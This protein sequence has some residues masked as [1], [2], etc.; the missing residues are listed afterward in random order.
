M[1]EKE[2]LSGE[3]EADKFF[4]FLPVFALISWNVTLKMYEKQRRILTTA[5][6]QNQGLLSLIIAIAMVFQSKRKFIIIDWDYTILILFTICLLSNVTTLGGSSK[7]GLDRY[8]P[9]DR[10]L[11]FRVSMHP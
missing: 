8:V 11:F 4:I 7:L 3:V 2:L 10:E 1:D 5:R 9:P 6:P